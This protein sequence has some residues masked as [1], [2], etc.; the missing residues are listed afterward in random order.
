MAP[1]RLE[2]KDGFTLLELIVSLTI[3]GVIVTIVLGAM[4]IGV[5]AWEKGEG[6]IENQQRCRIV[7]DRIGQQMASMVVPVD[8]PQAEAAKY[9]LKGD[10]ASVEFVSSI[11]LMPENRSGLVYVKYEVRTDGEGERSLSCYEQSLARRSPDPL[12]NIIEEDNFQVLLPHLKECGFAYFKLSIPEAAGKSPNAATDR[13]AEIK[14]MPAR[15]MPGE[16]NIGNFHGRCPG[17]PRSNRIIPA[18][19]P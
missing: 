3:L 18:P 7:L 8:V 5:R 14:K 6:D 2:N 1:E 15:L 13:N 9:L 11:S 12:E 10:A 17:I 4:R 16:M 19:L